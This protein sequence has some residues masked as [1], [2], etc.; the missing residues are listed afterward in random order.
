VAAAE[1]T[2]AHSS[3]HLDLISGLPNSFLEKTRPPN[4]GN[5]QIIKPTAGGGLYSLLL[6]V[7]KGL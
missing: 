5:F 4:L 2:R 3:L 7:G 1:T 6:L